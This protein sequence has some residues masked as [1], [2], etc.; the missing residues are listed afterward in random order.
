MNT[1]ELPTLDVEYLLHE[2]FQDCCDS[3]IDVSVKDLHRTDG[4]LPKIRVITS[5]FPTDAEI[6]G[7]KEILQRH[8]IGVVR[9]KIM[10]L[11]DEHDENRRGTE[12]DWSE[13]VRNVL[14]SE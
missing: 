6:R 12:K 3:V 5:D 8:D 10:T 4:A 2:T 9:L 1:K 7:M 11:L 13:K 14:K